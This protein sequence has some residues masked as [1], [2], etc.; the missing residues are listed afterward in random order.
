MS[1]AKHQ[2]EPPRATTEPVAKPDPAVQDPAKSEEQSAQT[3]TSFPPQPDRLGGESASAPEPDPQAE[4]AE[5]RER[6]LRS[7]ADM[8][9]LRKR[10]EREKAETAKYAIAR[11]AQDILSVGDNIRRAIDAVPPEAAK[12]DAA[13]QS[14][15]EGVEVT[16]K[17]LLSVFERHGI[18]R[19]DPKGEMFDPH[20][21][22][23]MFELDNP[24]VAAGTIVEVVQSGYMI[25]DR[26][27]RPT[28]VGVAKGGAK[29][30]K[31]PLEEAPQKSA[32]EPQPEPPPV[33]GENE[34]ANTGSKEAAFSKAGE[35]RK[36]RQ[37]EPPADP[38]RPD[39]PTNGKRAK[40]GMRVDRSA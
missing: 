23:A 3:E 9:N 13:L 16:E 6:L 2:N 14:L 1:H 34:P 37:P 35:A 28:L 31:P 17:G 26:V 4:I 33:S 15:L 40:P 27:L 25:A 24:N 39:R 32:S 21:H 12:N 8:D 18:R 10:T 19:V 29:I 36:E 20:V 30:P 22:Q 38:P 11:F 5:L 7:M